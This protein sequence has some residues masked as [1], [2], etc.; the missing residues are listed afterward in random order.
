MFN[1]KIKLVVVVVG[2]V[3]LLI[4]Y[5]FLTSPIQRVEVQRTIV[6]DGDL[7]RVS[8]LYGSERLTNSKDIR[9]LFGE[10]NNFMLVSKRYDDKPDTDWI[11]NS[12]LYLYS[13]DYG[14]GRDKV[15]SQKS[16]V[17]YAIFSKN[18][19]DIIFL[20]TERELYHHNIQSGKEDRIAIEA[21]TP[22]LSP[23]GKSLVYEKAPPGWI[24]AD[25]FEV[26]GLVILDIKTKKE[27]SLINPSQWNN[28]DFID[29]FPTWTPDGKHIIF[30][31]NGLEI[32]NIDGTKRTQLTKQGDGVLDYGI[33][34][35]HPLWSS[36]GGYLIFESNDEIVVMEL[37]LLNKKVI[38]AGP[39][40]YGISPRWVEEG[41][42]I[43]V[44][45]PDAKV[46]VPSLSIVDLNGK[47]LSG[48]KSHEKDYYSAFKG[49]LRRIK[50]KFVSPPPPPEP[51]KEVFL[52]FDNEIQVQIRIPARVDDSPEPVQ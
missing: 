47:V 35:S 13:I 31:G 16:N 33:W 52:K 49:A 7:Y 11:D 45:S 30:F 28:E 37:D 1:T 42:T 3:A 10:K 8:S 51:A 41:K 29:Y 4:G 24:F 9:I 15:F 32:V 18:A 34:S 46:G 26:P 5:N 12:H 23:D 38:T 21:T 22:Q 19:E 14:Y 43:S 17:E 20:T 36:D 6:I 40:A 25:F 44:F 50:P 48:D 27:R 39:I 2:V